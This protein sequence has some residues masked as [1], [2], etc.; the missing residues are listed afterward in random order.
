PDGAPT[1]AAVGFAQKMS[2]DP[3]A[4]QRVPTPKGEYLAVRR[5]AIGRTAGDILAEGLPRAVAAM[6]FPK[7]MRWGDGA[8]RFV[9]PVHWIV[10]LLGE[11]V[12]PFE[13]FGVPS[14]R[15]S[16]GH[17]VLGPRGSAAPSPPRTEAVEATARAAS[18]ERVDRT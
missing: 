12:V 6:T 7:T 4:L 11:A 1:R 2:V 17:R 3:S 5:R 16:A 13:L 9:R 18:S 8:R 10:A 14:G 15:E